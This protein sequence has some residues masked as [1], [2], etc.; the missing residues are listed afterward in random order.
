MKTIIAFLFFSFSLSAQYNFTSSSGELKGS[1][2]SASQS[3]G[4]IAYTYI[5]SDSGSLKQGVIQPY[6]ISV[7]SGEDISN[8][9][10]SLKA[11]P[12]PV[13]NILNLLVDENFI[14]KDQELEYQL[15]DING[16]L[17]E[18]NNISTAL[19][20][21]TVSQYPPAA[22]FLQVRAKNKPIKIFKIVKTSF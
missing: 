11:F 18:A 16:R 13:F 6:Q 9:E 19:T 1:G 12:N 22:Y 4:Q 17:L 5:Q 21:I 2:G 10:L 7:I 14:N 20:E 3:I 15:F 8:I